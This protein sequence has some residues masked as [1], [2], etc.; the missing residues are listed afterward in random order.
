MRVVLVDLISLSVLT[1]WVIKA[2][3]TQKS[4]IRT[5]ANQRSEGKLFSVNLLDQTVRKYNGDVKL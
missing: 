2:R 4:E 5:W 1:R 3:V